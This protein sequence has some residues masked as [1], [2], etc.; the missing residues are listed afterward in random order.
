[1][2][3]ASFSRA[4]LAFATCCECAI[5]SNCPSQERRSALCSEVHWDRVSADTGPCFAGLGVPA[6]GFCPERFPLYGTRHPRLHQ[7]GLYARPANPSV[8][9]IFVRSGFCPSARPAPRR[10][11][12]CSRSHPLP[13]DQMTA[14]PLAFAGRQGH[15]LVARTAKE[16]TATLVVVPR[17]LRENR[18]RPLSSGWID[19]RQ[20]LLSILRPAPDKR[21]LGD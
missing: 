11:S 13:S 9:F 17:S 18:N 6:T 3:R 2:S 16:S 8:R 1:M 4:G 20:S 21:R 19:Y 15:C 5:G 12:A 7:V 14:N 10:C